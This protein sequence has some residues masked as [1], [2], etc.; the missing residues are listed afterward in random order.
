M[1]P[2][3]RGLLAMKISFKLIHSN[4][5]YDKKLDAIFFKE[6]KLPQPDF[7]LQVGSGTHAQQTGNIMMKFEEICLKR[8]PKLIIVHGDT[9]TT[10]A[11]ALVAKKLHV[12]LAHVEA[13]LR[14]HDEKMPEEI[15]RCLVDRV[16]DFL[17]APTQ[18]AKKNLLADGISSKKIF[19]TGNTVVDAVLQNKDLL[20]KP[21]TLHEK[22]ILMTAHRPSNVDTDISMKKLIQVSNHISKKLSLPII[23]PVHPRCSKRAQAL[24][25]T[26]KTRIELTEPYGY[27]DMLSLLKNA[28]YILT[29]SGGIQ[30]EAYI[31]QKRLI[32]LRDTTERPETL[33]ANYLVDL[34]VEKMEKALRFYDKKKAHWNKKLGT[35]K[36]SQKIISI[37]QKAL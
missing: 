26:K 35:G 37:I 22:Y 11:G 28:E 30:E 9:N 7:N 18:E 12:P 36:A 14:S 32:T 33:S 2:I 5:H 4:Q 13:G 6:L 8:L 1:A 3:I 29:D 16:S 17:F 21:P 27:L 25:K 31:L 23:W 34:S 20:L 24:L 15:N 10:L 19:V